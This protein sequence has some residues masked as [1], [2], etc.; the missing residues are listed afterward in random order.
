MLDVLRKSVAGP[1]VKILI[2]VL[3]LSF[4]VWGIQD[5]FGNYKRTVAIEMGDYE[6]TID[7][8][9]NEYNKQLST[10]SS[11]LGKQISHREALSY[12]IDKLTIDNLLKKIIL[13]AEID[14]YKIATSETYVAREIV[15]DDMFK[16]DGKF[17][18]ARYEQLLS[19]AGYDEESFLQNEVNTNKQF[20]LFN[21]ISS[22]NYVP[23]ALLDMIHLYNN[24]TKKI[25]YT[26]LLRSEIDVKTPSES[27]LIEFYNKFNN[28]YKKSE[29]R[30]FEA[31]ILN[32]EL[33]AQKIKISPSQVKEYYEINKENFAQ[34][35]EREVYQ[36]FFNDISSAQ[37][38]YNA[39]N[40][41]PDID[42][43][44]EEFN[45][46]KDD[47]YLGFLTQDAIFD[48]K[49]SD[50]AFG[51]ERRTFSN[52]TEGE[53]GISVIYVDEI[54]ESKTPSLEEASDIIQEDLSYIEGQTQSDKLYYEI[55]ELILDNKT[56]NEISELYDLELLKLEKIDINGFDNDG[57]EVD[58]INN[59]DILQK[60][61]ES[62]TDDFIEVIETN[63]NTFVWINLKSI[64]KP[65]IRSFKEVRSLVTSDMIEKRRND[66]EIALIEEIKTVINSNSEIPVSLQKYLT[67]STISNE[68]SRN[69]P[70]KEFSTDFNEKV[71]SANIGDII[72]GKSSSDTL[73]AKV[74]E[75]NKPINITQPDIKIIKN[76][77]TQMKNDLF[78]QYLSNL[79]GKY[80]VKVFQENIDRLFMNQS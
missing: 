14:K 4:A 80:N 2:G 61:F 62:E 6:I 20:Q 12:G 72:I 13:K 49:I 28:G 30:D 5:I 55:E 16:S 23:D 44:I 15:N 1:F 33:L 69:N 34:D 25:E 41:N 29:T 10:V 27:E 38:L 58:I 77:N 7:D 47:V 9:I 70:I 76:L 75:V 51:L 46:K 78:E 21:V 71:L 11:Q 59:E 19:Y 40:K 57:I 53:F 32:A 43:L 48:K 50:I 66:R 74:I 64:N 24:S 68:F 63:D 60:I 37:E 52:P 73:I 67:E 18:K 65:Y 56:I 17:N 36:F 35:E 39:S 54:T 45:F 31:L 3:I 79:Q 22:T 42:I 8:F 26:K